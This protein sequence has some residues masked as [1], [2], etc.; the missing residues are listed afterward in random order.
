MIMQAVRLL[1]DSDKELEHF[2][3]RLL[4]WHGW[5]SP[6]VGNIVTESVTFVKVVKKMVFQTKAKDTGLNVIGVP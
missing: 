6:E 5:H 3:M 2:A 4:E 1:D